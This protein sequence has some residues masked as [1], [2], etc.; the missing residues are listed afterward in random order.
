MNQSHTHLE[1]GGKYTGLYVATFLANKKSKVEDLADVLVLRK[2]DSEDMAVQMAS[3][4][5]AKGYSVV[6]GGKLQ[7]A[8]GLTL[9]GGEPMVVYV[10]EQRNVWARE[11]GEFNTRFVPPFQVPSLERAVGKNP[12]FEA[13]YGNEAPADDTSTDGVGA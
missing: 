10:S 11:L 4:V 9:K 2:D 1:K 6:A 5:I 8:D 3:D 13:P 12:N 7:K